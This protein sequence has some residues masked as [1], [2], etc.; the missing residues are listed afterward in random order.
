MVFDWGP[1]LLAVAKRDVPPR[2]VA[3][4]GDRRAEHRLELRRRNRVS[5]AECLDARGKLPGAGHERLELLQ[6][7]IEVTRGKRWRHGVV[8]RLRFLVE[9]HSRALQHPD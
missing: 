5:L 1:Q 9:R 6:R 8:E 2:P 4:F 7:A 3:T